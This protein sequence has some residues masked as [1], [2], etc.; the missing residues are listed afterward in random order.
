MDGVPLDRLTRRSLRALMGVVSQD[1]VL[2]NDT[3]HA[4]IAYGSPARH[5]AQVEAAAEAANAAEL[6][7]ALPQGYDT[8]L[9]E[10]GTRLSG[11]QRQRIA[12][13]RALLRDPPILILDEATS[14]LDTE[15]GAPGA[16]GDRTA[17]AGPDGAGDRPPAG[18]RA[19]RR[20]DRGARRRPRR[21]AREP[22][23]SCF[24]P[25][26]S[27][28]GSTI[29]SSATTRASRT[30]RVATRILAYDVRSSGSYS[31]E[32]CSDA[33]AARSDGTT[34]WCRIISAGPR[35]AR[36]R[37]RRRAA[38]ACRPPAPRARA[39]RLP[40]HRA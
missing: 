22:R 29:C 4:N 24:A 7:R 40:G 11:G 33:G 31:V 27:I 28:A 15:I 14:A 32:E 2:L 23:R 3:V 9:G 5:A 35:P 34:G 39:T 13:A 18:H 19:G 1:T 8:V 30:W 36:G 10:R 16:A 20:R 25:A 38:R 37:L 26:G 6:H 17:D 21:A 12:I